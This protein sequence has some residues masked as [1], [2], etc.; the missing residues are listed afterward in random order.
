MSELTII[1]Q[2]LELIGAFIGVCII[3]LVFPLIGRGAYKLI[4][5][6]LPRK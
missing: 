1:S 2:V 3:C 5:G 6:L 4:T